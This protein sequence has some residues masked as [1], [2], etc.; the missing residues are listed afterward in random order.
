MNSFV[1][2]IAFILS[3]PNSIVVAQIEKFTYYSP[4]MVV[5]V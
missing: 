1:W 5:F 2:E 4:P 3:D